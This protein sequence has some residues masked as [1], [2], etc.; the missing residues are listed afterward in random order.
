MAVGDA[1]IMICSKMKW[2]ALEPDHKRKIIRKNNSRPIHTL[3]PKVM[4]PNQTNTHKNGKK[5][6]YFAPSFIYISMVTLPFSCLFF[7]VSLNILEPDWIYEA[8]CA[9]AAW[10][11]V[12]EML[13]A[14][15]RTCRSRDIPLGLGPAL[16]CWLRIGWFPRVDGCAPSIS[17]ARHFDA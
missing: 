17:I 13:K 6:R 1:K 15:Q 16:L 8:C 10:R 2:F 11:V 7:F 3:A 5:T 9:A 4:F 14:T 12:C